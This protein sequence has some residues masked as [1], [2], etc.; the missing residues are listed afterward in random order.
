MH[1]ALGM[2][3]SENMM[4]ESQWFIIM[5]PINKYHLETCPIFSP[6]LQ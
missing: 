5:L 6:T 4:V 2:G 3:F 1:H